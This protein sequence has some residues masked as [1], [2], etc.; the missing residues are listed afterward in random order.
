MNNGSPRDKARRW[1]ARAE[2]V[3]QLAECMWTLDCREMMETIAVGYDIMA[4]QMEEIG[5]VRNYH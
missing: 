1:R 3:R 4:A 5:N 2:E